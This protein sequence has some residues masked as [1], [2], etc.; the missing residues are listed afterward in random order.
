MV[1]KRYGKEA[2]LD[3]I[4]A[5]TKTKWFHY[6]DKDIGMTAPDMVAKALGHFGV[7]ADLKYGSLDR[8]K[9]YVNQ[10]K[11]PIVLVRSSYWTWH[12]VVVIGYDEE[13]IIVADPGGGER[14]VMPTAHFV[15]AWSFATDMRGVYMAG[16]CGTC[17]GDGNWLPFM[18][19][20]IG[21]CEVCQGTGT[22]DDLLVLALRIAEI[23]PNTM[24]VP[25]AAAPSVA[26]PR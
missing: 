3:Q 16:T 12:Y 25:N 6:K 17:G 14:L 18:A 13:N 22:K 2:T 8:L 10:N 15:G 24:I 1:L 20:P 5:K 19:G 21:K 4:K 11:P 7:P 23:H 26:S 9:H